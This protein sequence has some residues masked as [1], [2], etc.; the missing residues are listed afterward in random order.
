MENMQEMAVNEME[1][2]LLRKFEEMGMQL[3][4]KEKKYLLTGFMYYLFAL[5]KFSEEEIYEEVASAWET[6]LAD[7]KHVYHKVMH[8]ENS[9]EGLTRFCGCKPEMRVL[10]ESCVQ[11]LCEE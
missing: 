6:S 11:T 3:D 8:G 1:N 9:L 10:F 7:V 5:R 4:E 2:K